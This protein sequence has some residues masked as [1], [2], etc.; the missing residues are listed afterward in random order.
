MN[1]SKEAV[2]KVAVVITSRQAKQSSSLIFTGL[3]RAPPS[4][5]RAKVPFET[6][7]SFEL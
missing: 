4:Q 2:S 1:I 6:A 5:W 3:L 7:S